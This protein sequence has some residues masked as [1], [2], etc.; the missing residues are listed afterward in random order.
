MQTPSPTSH[1]SVNYL[2]KSISFHFLSTTRVAPETS[3]SVA[4]A[5]TYSPVLLPY[6]TYQPVFCIS[7][8]RLSP[9]L[10]QRP[11]FT[12]PNS[13]LFAVL[14]STNPESGPLDTCAT[15][16]AIRLSLIVFLGFDTSRAATLFWS[17][18]LDFMCLKADTCMSIVT[19]SQNV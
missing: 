17:L 7:S 8:I 12:L 10:L 3:R 1:H 14:V 16:T 15:P 13:A 19:R 5:Y 4:P 11:C 9:R 18:Q 6:S 2:D